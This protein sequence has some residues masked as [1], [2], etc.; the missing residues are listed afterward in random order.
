MD[1]PFWAWLAV[2]AAIAVML[3]VDLFAHRHAHVIA[4]R[5]AAIWTLVWVA[6][7]VAFGALIWSVY[8]AELGQQYFA[9][10]VIEKSLAV[11]NVFVWAIIFT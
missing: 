3:A 5:E 10:Y 4:V 9:G 7:G 6:C 1:V 8:G 2:L 11:D